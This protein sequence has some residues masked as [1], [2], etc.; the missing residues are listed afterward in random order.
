MT[1][2]GATQESGAAALPKGP[3]ICMLQLH[4]YNNLTIKMVIIWWLVVGTPHTHT[5]AQAHISNI[6]NDHQ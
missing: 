5:A 4:A 1:L 2:V 6:Q 3:Y